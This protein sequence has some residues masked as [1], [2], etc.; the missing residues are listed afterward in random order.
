VSTTRLRILLFGCLAVECH[1]SGLEAACVTLA[2]D[3]PTNN[4]D[5]TPLTDL[6]G[7]KIYY[8]TA[9][10]TYSN[11]VNVGLVTTAAVVN[12][13][14]GLTYF[15]AATCYDTS[16]NESDFSAELVWTSLL[17]N[18]SLTVNSAQGGAVPGTV[19]ANYGTALS[20]AVVNSPLTAGTTQYVCTG[21]AV[22]GNAFTAV[23]PTNVTLTLT[24]N[25]TLTW[26]WATNY[27]FARVSGTNGSVSGSASGW[28]AAGGSATVMATANANYHFGRWSG[29][30]QGDANSA[31]LTLTLDR[32]R[33]VTANFAIT[34][35]PPN[36]TQASSGGIPPV[37]CLALAEEGVKMGIWGTVG[38]DLWVQT[39]SNLANPLAWD[40]GENLSLTNVAP[41]SDGT[42]RAAPQNALE[43]A[44]VPA[45][46]WFTPTVDP[47][48]PVRFFRV[49]M[50]YDHAVL[51]GNVLKSKGY[52]TRLIV[53]RLPGE[54]LHD[55]C[56]VGEDKA[57]V[58]C[59]ED[60]FLLALNYSGATIR[61]IADDYGGFVSMNWTSASEFVF[62]NGVRELVSTV[63]KTD[64][65][66]SDP[67]LA[68]A[69]A[70]SIA[71][72]F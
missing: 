58:D 25:A 43:A 52:Q 31:A 45:F 10:L 11:I 50:P 38:A 68:I 40:P 12:L 41:S 56:Y 23:S 60:R 34:A 15:F 53:V 57:Y 20:Q 54:T 28:V 14:T 2:W 6:A 17:S 48:C 9:S 5:G 65:P 70:S 72:N 63:V 51:A 37:V 27:A 8:G 42:P 18:V 39:S 3:P 55:V 1:V 7:Y 46:Q 16:S 35:S 71:V 36:I 64:S 47:S 49:A 26:Q 30:V 59:S 33:T 29:D 67:P 13:P 62:T 21:A 22:L 24:N 4:T 66:S 32:P 19:T 69:Q 61:E 44:F